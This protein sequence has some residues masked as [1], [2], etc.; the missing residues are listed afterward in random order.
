MADRSAESPLLGIEHAC[1]GCEQVDVLERQAGEILR[2][3]G[4]VGFVNEE[5]T[6][7]VWVGRDSIVDRPREERLAQAG[8]VIDAEVLGSNDSLRCA[9]GCL[10]AEVCLSDVYRDVNES[11]HQYRQGHKWHQ[12]P[13][14][15]IVAM[16]PLLSPDDEVTRFIEEAFGDTATE[17][18]AAERPTH[19]TVHVPQ[20]DGTIERFTIRRSEI[21]SSQV[22]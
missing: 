8:M 21:N 14:E 13:L 5:G 2:A 10:L 12:M 4:M 16:P 22:Q 18:Q 9:A 15:D 11:N 6:V 3:S 19:G 17:H 1:G 20:V 7:R